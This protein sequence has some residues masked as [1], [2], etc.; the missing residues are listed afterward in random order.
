MNKWKFGVVVMAMLLI[1]AYEGTPTGPSGDQ[2]SNVGSDNINNQNVTIIMHDHNEDGGDDGSQPNRPPVLDTPTAQT[3]VAGV[4]VIGVT[5]RATD[6]DGD[7]LTYSAR[8]LPRGLTINATSGII[9]GEISPSSAGD[10]P[11]NVFVSVSD[12]E[13]TDSGSF[14]WTVTPTVP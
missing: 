1:V 9:S 10:S 14:L 4:F 3:N 12:G 7:F 8:N 2:D 13:L 6:P 5:I 11:F